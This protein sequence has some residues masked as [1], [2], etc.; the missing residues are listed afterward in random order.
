MHFICCKH[1]CMHGNPAGGCNAAPTVERNH[2]V[3]Y[4]A[5]KAC[6][7]LEQNANKT[8]QILA[9]N[10]MCCRV[11]TSFRERERVNEC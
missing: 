11:I 10:E 1:A 4:T 7:L 3:A 5:T 9:L 2:L 8:E 6:K